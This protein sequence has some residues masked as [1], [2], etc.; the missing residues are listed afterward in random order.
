MLQTKDN[1][2]HT[3]SKQASQQV[4]SMTKTKTIL[5]ISFAA[6]FAV[7]MIA[8]QSVIADGDHLDIVKSEIEMNSDSITEAELE[9][10]GIIPEINGDP[11]FF[12]FAIVTDGV[13][14]AAT[15][16]NGFFDS[17]TQDSDNPDGVWHV[18]MV[19]ATTE[20]ACDSGLA[21]ARVSFEENG[22]VEV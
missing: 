8:S 16:H 20:T 17:E 19:E 2:V 12:G 13:L 14:A 10:A 5:G 1:K 9:T 22:E 4:D 21:I 6:L 3:K 11:S 18:H 7:T 15:T